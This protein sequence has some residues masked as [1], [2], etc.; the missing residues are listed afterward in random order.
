MTTSSESV[1]Y[2]HSFSS[3]S[4]P[5]R[6]DSLFSLPPL[7]CAYLNFPSI[8]II[9]HSEFKSNNSVDSEA[10]LTVYLKSLLII[11]SVLYFSSFS[12]R[13][14]DLLFIINLDT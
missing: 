7:L 3:C 1:I 13:L 5:L 12:F 11:A 2:I 9:M 14:L 4:S 8:F 10:R 6:F